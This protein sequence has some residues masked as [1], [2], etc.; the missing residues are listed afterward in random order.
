MSYYTKDDKIYFVQIQSN[1]LPEH[2]Y[3]RVKFIM[4]RNIKNNNDYDE[5]IIYSKIHINMKY[6]K[7]EYPDKI[8]KKLKNF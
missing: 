1:E 4:N 2:F 8:V 5:A 3:E 7:C 6:Y